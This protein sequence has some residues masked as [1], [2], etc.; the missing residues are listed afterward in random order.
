MKRYLTRDKIAKLTGR[1][2][3]WVRQFVKG[4]KESGRYPPDEVI[5]DGHL[6]LIEQ[7]VVLDWLRNRNKL[8]NGETVA[9][10]KEEEA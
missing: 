10:Y 2:R 1:K 8:K 4:L 6:I 9:P 5:E 3:E 7:G